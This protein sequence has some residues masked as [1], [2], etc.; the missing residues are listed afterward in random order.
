MRTV[1]T[2]SNP[3]P[4]SAFL[5]HKAHR[6]K[7]ALV[8]AGGHVG[9]VGSIDVSPATREDREGCII[10]ANN[11]PLL[12]RCLRIVEQAETPLATEDE[13]PDWRFDAGEMRFVRTSP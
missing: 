9:T 5:P 6:V 10:S 2:P 4:V 12:Q 1:M 3:F 13:Y 11:Q 8:A 7:Q